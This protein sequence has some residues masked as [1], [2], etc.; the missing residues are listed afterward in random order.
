MKDLF[1]K[2]ILLFF[3]VNLSHSQAWMTDLDIAQKLALVQNKMVLMVW[4][5]TTKYQYPV[6][7]KDEKGRTLLIENLFDDETITP[8][9]W[10]NF[11]PVIVSENQYADLYLKI[12]DNRKQSYIDKFNDDSIKIMDINGNILNVSGFLDEYP[13]ITKL[14]ERYALNTIFIAHELTGYKNEN[15]FYSAYY[16]AAKYLDF[17][18]YANNNIRSEIINLSNIYLNEA[19]ALSEMVATED[20]IMLKQRC[21]L[22]KIQ[23]YLVLKRPKKV[24]RQLKKMDAENIENSNNSFAAFLYYIAYTILDD[25]INAETWKAKVSL[26]NLKKAEMII[27]LNS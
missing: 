4:E 13:N 25:E 11:V 21:E 19:M 10:E 8:L 3:A 22:L 2:T 9:I 6:L 23:E 5:E 15:D 1:T 12:R 24:L 16:L 26:V 18:L 20:K 7:V 17:S 14:I 27:N